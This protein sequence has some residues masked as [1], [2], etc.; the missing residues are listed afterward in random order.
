MIYGYDMQA[1][2]CQLE[3]YYNNQFATEHIYAGD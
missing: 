1:I 2:D 3:T